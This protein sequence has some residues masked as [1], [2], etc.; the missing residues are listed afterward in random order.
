MRL[1]GSC[2]LLESITPL[3]AVCCFCISPL[4]AQSN[5]SAAPKGQIRTY[6]VAADELDWDYAP[7]GID[8]MMNMPFESIAKSY[9][10]HGPHRIGHIYKKAIFREYTD[11]T[12]TVLKPRPP[13]WE[14]AG[15]LGPILRAEVGDTIKIIFRN[16]G[17]HPYS[18]HPHGVFYEKD[19]EGTAYNDG[20]DATAKA[21]G[22]VPP[23]QTHT[24][25]W[26]VPERAGP[27][28]RDPD[29]IVWLYHSH[30]NEMI[31]VNAGLIGAMI[32]TRRGM[33]LPDGRPKDVDKEFV[34]LY[35]IFDENQS[36]FLEENI[37]KHTGDPAGT[38]KDELFPV[39]AEGHWNFTEPTG[40]AGVNLRMTINGMQYANL[41]MMTMKKGDRVRWYLVTIGFGFNFHTPHWHGNVILND[42]K[43][44]DVVALSPAQMVTTDM[45]PDDPGI[46]LFH[47]HVSD[48][49][50]GGMIARYQVLQ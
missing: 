16:N 4:V 14:H 11:A 23:G 47:C 2:Q 35:M 34:A 36:W 10:E 19:S 29:S 20:S 50:D 25:T 43:R 9:M 42:G 12:F 27:G 3:L 1:L 39:D 21:G 49:M 15:I 6:Y 45:V 44:T 26:E 17:T 28:P 33:A 32:I 8:Q 37:Q 13:E 22:H 40:F 5:V 7:S 31:D 24:Y 46:W 38:K 48:H 30:V 18:M 41:P